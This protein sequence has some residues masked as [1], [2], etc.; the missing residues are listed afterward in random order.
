MAF[1]RH[2]IILLKKLMVEEQLLRLFR[3]SAIR[4]RLHTWPPAWLL[5][6]PGYTWNSRTRSDAIKHLP[7]RLHYEE[8]A[9]ASK[10]VLKDL[11]FKEQRQCCQRRSVQKQAQKPEITS[12]SPTSS[13]TTTKTGVQSLIQFHLQKSQS[14]CRS[15]KWISSNKWHKTSKVLLS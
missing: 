8:P 1:K 7:I 6:P 11:L 4:W 10:F 13:K 14:F 9:N 15:L 2:M 3:F 12:K 5:L